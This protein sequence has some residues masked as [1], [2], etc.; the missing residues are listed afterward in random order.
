MGCH[1][2]WIAVVGPTVDY[3]RACE[4]AAGRTMEILLLTQANC[5]LCEQAKEILARLCLEYPLAVSTLDCA[6]PDGEA[7]ATRAG[8][9][10]PPGVLLDGEPFTYGGLSE[11]G[12][13]KEIERRLASAARA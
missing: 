4:D 12:L 8:I 11:R 6:T 13:R 5:A 9:L 10:F 7:L 1:G 2:R 3:C